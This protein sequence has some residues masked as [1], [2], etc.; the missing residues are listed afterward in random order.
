MMNG[1]THKVT[2]LTND[3]ARLIVDRLD[4]TD[5]VVADAAEKIWTERGDIVVREEER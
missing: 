5:A 2:A 3:K 1:V 4:T